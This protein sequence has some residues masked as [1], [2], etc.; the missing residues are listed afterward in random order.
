MNDE[1]DNCSLLSNK[2]QDDLDQDG[3]GDACDPDDDGDGVP[4]GDDLCPGSDDSLDGD[5]DGAPDGC[6]NCEFD[7]NPDQADLNGDGIGDA[8][9]GVGP[10]SRGDAN[11][12]GSIDITDPTYTL[13]FLFLGGELP[14]CM[15]AADANHDGQI[16]IS[17]PTYT[18]RYL[19]LG[20]TSHFAPENC[21][22]SDSKT[23]IA[24]GCAESVCQ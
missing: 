15:A 18:L 8:C 6:D 16:D 14:G 9:D 3:L 24:A 11:S 13:R 4:D 12:D 7:A 2:G 19:F 23:D 21:G 1:D 10:F 22:N 5:G 20:G 17:D